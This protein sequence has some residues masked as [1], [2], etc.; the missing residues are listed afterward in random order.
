MKK[1]RRTAS[2]Q[3]QNIFVD[4]GTDQTAA[5]PPHAQTHTHTCIKGCPCLRMKVCYTYCVSKANEFN[6]RVPQSLFA[7]KALKKTNHA[8]FKFF[9]YYKPLSNFLML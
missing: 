4:S 7:L 1:R 3:F 6:A 9:N 2:K 8:A 5:Q